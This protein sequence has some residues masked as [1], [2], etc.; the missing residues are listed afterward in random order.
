MLLAYGYVYERQFD[1]APYVSLGPNRWA[2]LAWPLKRLAVNGTSAFVFNHEGS[3]QFIFLFSTDGSEWRGLP[4][5]CRPPVEAPGRPP[6]I[7]WSQDGESEEVLEFGL[8]R[9]IR[10]VK[11]DYVNL[12]T[13]R[14]IAVSILPGDKGLT[15]RAYA[16][17]LVNSIFRKESP[18][19]RQCILHGLIGAKTRS[20]VGARKGEQV[21]KALEHI[22]PEDGAAC[23][24]R[25]L[26]IYFSL[27]L[28]S[29][30][31]SVSL[32]LP[33]LLPPLSHTHSLPLYS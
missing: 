1:M 27:V 3:P 26:S 30:S 29:L 15:V 2:A 8:R 21:L 9:G 22:A 12:C 13:D 11:Q 20:G 19:T 16:T 32:S 24:P 5:C 31:V 23:C 17:A 33:Y 28:L 25:A 10:L 4:T 14:K 7:M 18:E 6:A